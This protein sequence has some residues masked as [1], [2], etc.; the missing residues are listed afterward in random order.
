MTRKVW[1]PVY[2]F[3]YILRMQE[4]TTYMLHIM[5]TLHL[6]INTTVDNKTDYPLSVEKDVP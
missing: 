1:G 2:R 4:V 5:Y 3:L 6:Y